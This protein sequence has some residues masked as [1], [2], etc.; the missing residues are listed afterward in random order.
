MW[1]KFIGDEKKSGL[2]NGVMYRVEV[3]SQTGLIHVKAKINSDEFIEHIYVTPKH[4]AEN[5]K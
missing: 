4:F 5:W 2:K 3:F 1:L